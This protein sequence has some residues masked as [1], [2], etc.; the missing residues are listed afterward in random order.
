MLPVLFP[1]HQASAPQVLPWSPRPSRTQDVHWRGSIA[2]SPPA[3]LCETWLAHSRMGCVCSIHT[4][5]PETCAYTVRSPCA[6]V[7][8]CV[9][10]QTQVRDVL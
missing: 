5:G 2:G 4:Q 9:H 7:C 6:D 10:T 8:T 3:L 1:E